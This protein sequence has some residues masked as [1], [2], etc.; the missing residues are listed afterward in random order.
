M[1]RVAWLLGLLIVVLLSSPT[2]NACTCG[3][4]G[5]VC[6]NYGTASAV[7]TGTVVSA[8]ETERPKQLKRDEIDWVPAG[9]KFAV[10]Q[11]FLGVAGTEV[12]V[13]TGR[14]GGDCGYGFKIGQ[15][16]LVYAYRY[17][18]KL[19]TSICTR[20]KLF[21]QATEDLAFLGTLAT[22]GP[23]VTIHGGIF[24]R[25]GDKDEP[26]SSDVSVII[27]GESQRKEVRPDAEGRFRVS[28]LPA[29]KYKVTLKLP[30]ALTTWKNENEITVSDRG[31]GAVSWYVTDNGRVNGR[32]VDAEGQPV[33]KI[34]VGLVVPGNNPK[35]N[36]VKL[37]RTDEEGNFKFTAVPRGRY[38]LT[39]NH[40][41]F[42]EM[43]DP[44]R[45]YPPSFYPGVIDEA[46]AQAI[47]VG[48]GEKVNDLVVR[49]PPKQPSAV[50]K[51]SVVW[52]DGSPVAKA[53]LTVTD[54]TQSD[55]TLGYALDLDDQGQGAFDGYIG[56]K[57]LID[58]RSNRPYVPGKTPYEPMERAERVRLTVEHATETVRIVIT[59]LR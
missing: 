34:L 56:Q 24:H 5:G 49:V 20:T 10:E 58:A 45:A 19:T 14:G 42:P 21:S 44:T 41:R 40:N 53:S 22:A 16:Y 15:R 32:V 37:D 11:S 28:G 6:E 57:L 31:C 12:E 9:Y 29:G 59:K 13:F 48:P 3:G 54:I 43:N 1:R 36:F 39:V 27:E 38:L 50:M 18:D 46:Q 17:Q 8:R 23:G 2:A 7:F 26:I 25:N 35:E 52:A 51:V 33:A 30:D 4:G 55:N 47:T